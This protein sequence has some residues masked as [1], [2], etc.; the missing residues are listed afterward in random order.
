M[1]CCL[2]INLRK[3]L[4]S[5]LCFHYR[6]FKHFSDVT[7][8][9]NKKEGKTRR[10]EI[11]PD[12]DDEESVQEFPQPQDVSERAEEVDHVDDEE[13]FRTPL[14]DANNSGADLESEAASEEQENGQEIQVPG[15]VKML[16]LI[17]QLIN[18]YRVSSCKFLL[19][20]DFSIHMYTVLYTKILKKELSYCPEIPDLDIDERAEKL[21]NLSYRFHFRFHRK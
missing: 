6:W 14:D 3:P 21:A 1:N 12:N 8:A 19:L 10:T 16:S 15:I 5:T 2:S 7:D 13:L 4:T 11:T 20:L 17:F 18:I 9:H